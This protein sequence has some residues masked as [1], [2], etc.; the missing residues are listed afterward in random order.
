MFASCRLL[1][2]TVSNVAKIKPY[3]IYKTNRR[4]LYFMDYNPHLQPWKRSEPNKE[5]G[6]GSIEIPDEIEN[7]VHQTRSALT[8]RLRKPVG[9]GARVNFW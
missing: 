2:L 8:L 6:K 9:R 1:K 5:A 3:F 7:I 4:E